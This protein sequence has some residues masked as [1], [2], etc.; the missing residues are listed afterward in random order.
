M[1]VLCYQVSRWTEL[2]ESYPLN[3]NFCVHKTHPL[4]SFVVLYVDQTYKVDAMKGF[5][6]ERELKLFRTTGPQA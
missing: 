5:E 1:F 6:V 2:L 4:E 3:G